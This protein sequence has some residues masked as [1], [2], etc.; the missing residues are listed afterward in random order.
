MNT[1]KEIKVIK[2]NMTLTELSEIKNVYFQDNI[3]TN[4]LGQTVT[5]ISTTGIIHLT[6]AQGYA[7]RNAPTKI[8]LPSDSN[9]TF[10]VT[11]EEA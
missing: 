7:N 2:E 11:P 1:V 4:D 9:M 10:T 3:F 5:G 6:K 8:F